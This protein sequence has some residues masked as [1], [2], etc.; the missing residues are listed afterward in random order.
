MHLHS[1]LLLRMGIWMCAYFSSSKNDSAWGRKR[2]FSSQIPWQ[3]TLQK[4]LINAAQI[5]QFVGSEQVARN[6]NILRLRPISSVLIWISKSEHVSESPTLFRPFSPCPQGEAGMSIDRTNGGWLWSIAC[7]S[8]EWTPWNCQSLDKGGFVRVC[9][10]CASIK[11]CWEEFPARCNL[12]Q[13]DELKCWH[14]CIHTIPSCYLN[15][16]PK[17]FGS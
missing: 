15:A 10:A 13:L 5:N 11:V 14:V 7:C 16:W 3:C 1:L 17:P 12:W 9:C 2:L 6:H 4:F 8:S